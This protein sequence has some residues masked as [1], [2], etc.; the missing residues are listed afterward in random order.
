MLIGINEG[1]SST[2]ICSS[3]ELKEVEV[4]HE[5]SEYIV[6][7]YNLIIKTVMA[8]GIDE[9][10]AQDLVSD[11]YINLYEAENNG[12]G[13]DADY[14]DGGIS[15]SQFVISRALQYAKNVKYSKE[16]M[17]V[18][19]DKMTVKEVTEVPLLNKDGSYKR[20]RHGKIKTEKIVTVKT[21]KSNI[22]VHAATSNGMDSEDGNDGFQTAYAMA[23]MPAEDMDFTGEREIRQYIDTCI[24]ICG[25]HNY[26]IL[27]VLKNISELASII[28]VSKTAAVHSMFNKL[29]NLVNNN[30]EL[31]E[32]IREIFTFRMNNL[33]EY[34]NIIACY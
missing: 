3:T 27:P 26:D 21:V 28:A 7:N 31:G 11:M 13:Y 1:F 16:F 10:R 8:K 25:L 17:D 4:N 30:D 18:A 6:N 34:E 24:D 32:A 9:E 14:G 12:E 19:T 22:T 29:T 20:D 23:A 2:D 5:A 33:D 15:V